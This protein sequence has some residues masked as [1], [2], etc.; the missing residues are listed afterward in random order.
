M[1]TPVNLNK[2]RKDRARTA[3]KARADENSVRFGQTKVQKDV[4]KIR[5]DQADRT[6]DGHKRET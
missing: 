5:A 2:F 6:L 3:K 4:Q 1:T